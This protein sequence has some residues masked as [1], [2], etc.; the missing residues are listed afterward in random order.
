MASSFRVVEHVV[1]GC[2]TRDYVGATANGDADIP[3]LSVKQYTPLDNLN[4]KPGDITIIA[5][6]ANGFPKELYEPLWDEIQKRAPETRLRIRSIWI[7]DMWNQGQSSILNEKILG[8]DL[9]QVPN[10]S[11]LPALAST[12][13]RDIWPSEKEAAER[14]RGS[15][16]FQSWDPRVLDRWIKYGLRQLPTELHPSQ[17]NDERVTLTT[18]KHQELLNFLRPTYREIPGEEYVDK[19]PSADEEYPGYPFYRPEPLQV[20]QRLPELR[21]SVLYIFG[22]K[23]ELSPVDERQAKMARTGTGVGGS[24]GAAAG[25]VK[26]AV[27]DCGHLVAMER[28]EQCA[29]A[30][31]EFLGAELEQWR[32]E[33]AEYDK[34]WNKKSRREQITIDDKWAERVNPD[35][36]NNKTKL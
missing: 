21:P 4:P 2:H 14:F 30:I 33:E 26:E 9:I 32:Q 20:F 25:R 19:D 10:G 11:V 22:E 23:S 15:K 29:D 13:R 16:F 6:H 31:T 7:A 12:P 36:R 28:V 27:L 8:N 17:D 24:G 5:A 35:R 18:T 34:Y 3:K 1:N